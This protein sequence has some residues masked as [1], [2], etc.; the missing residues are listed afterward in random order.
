V[1]GAWPDAPDSRRRRKLAT[2]NREQ[3]DTAKNEDV[4]SGAQP[5]PRRS[6][7]RE[8]EEAKKK[9]RKRRS[10][11]DQNDVDEKNGARRAVHNKATPGTPPARCDP[12]H[13]RM[14]NAQRR[15]EEKRG[16]PD[17]TASS[18]DDDDREEARARPR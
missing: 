13:Q 16:N 12:A 1:S 6:P 15:A 4:S 17:A 3:T 5:K 9:K 18:D 11:K 7:Q 2:Q 14:K 10:E 8:K